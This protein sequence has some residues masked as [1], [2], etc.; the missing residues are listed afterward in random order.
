MIDRFKHKKIGVV[1]GGLSAERDVSLKTGAGVLAALQELAYDAIGIDWRQG[2][3]LPSCSPTPASAWCG[4]RCTAPTARTARCRACAPASASR[5]PAPASWPARWRWTRSRRSASSR[6]TASRPRGGVPCQ[7]PATA[8]PTAPMPSPRSPTG[9]CRWWSSP[10]TRAA[11]SA[12]RSS[13]IATSSPPPWRWPAPS[14]ARSWSRTTSPAPRSSSASST[15]PCS[16]RS[17]SSPPTRFYDYEA[18]YL[19]NDTRYLI[20]PEVSPDIVARAEAHALAAYHALGCAG[21]ARPD[22]RDRSR[23][24]RLGPRGQHPARHDRHQPAPQDRQGRRHE[25]PAAVRADPVVGAMISGRGRGA[26][27]CRRR[28]TPGRAR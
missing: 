25:L 11:R 8:P 18:K 2:T 17:R 12:S 10:P 15:A 21:H 9:G 14:T 23:R 1:L 19:R 13:T 6:A 7:A 4:T 5:A 20:P 16:A 3:S 24:Q 22:L 28:S 27:R 26:D